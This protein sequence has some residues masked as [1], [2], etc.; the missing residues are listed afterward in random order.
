M[1]NR[2]TDSN[3]T[4]YN[5]VANLVFTEQVNTESQLKPGAV[6]AGCI[7]F[8]LYNNYGETISM[9]T[10]LTYYQVDENDNATLI[11]TF[12]VSTVEQRRM[13]QVITAY[14]N[15][16][17]L[18]H[19]FSRKLAQLQ[20]SFPISANGFV[21]A[22]CDVAGVE[23]DEVAFPLYD[24]EFQKF[25]ADKI[26]CRQIISWVAEIACCFVKCNS[27]GKLSLKWY[28]ENEDYHIYPTSGESPEDETYVFYKLNGLAYSGKVS[29][30]VEIV[31]IN[32]DDSAENIYYYPSE[33]TQ[34]YA[35]D[36]SGNGDLRLYHFTATD[37]GDTT[38]GDII[39]QN[40]MLYTFDTTGEGNLSVLENQEY[41]RLYEI[42][43]NL[44]LRN[45]NDSTL[46]VISK[47]LYDEL[48]AFPVFRNTQVDLFMFFNPF[49][50]GEIARITDIRD[51]SYVFPI[52]K[53]EFGNGVA[54]LSTDD[55]YGN[56][57]Y[58]ISDD[59]YPFI[60][61]NSS[62]MI[63]D[64]DKVFYSLRS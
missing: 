17:K 4:V 35:E 21:R 16:I 39:L 29:S 42:T 33:F 27:N 57:N 46:E 9:D 62:E 14:D 48:N 56:S 8:D 55:L 23:W 5:N 51:L 47:H 1:T 12:I 52:M 30:A 60:P 50:A 10:E 31:K 63:T 32:L 7:Q 3:G 41:V 64:D 59:H 15:I 54:R 49:R 37:T 20:N 6:C 36:T 38:Y 58:K 22:A 25:Y 18:D 34:A 13:K 2:V 45:A 53:M 43:D 28:T 11:G 26:S 40:S 61:L 19:D 44:L 24:V